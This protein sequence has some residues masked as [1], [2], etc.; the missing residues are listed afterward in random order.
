[1]LPQFLDRGPYT[2]THTHTYTGIYIYIYM[3]FLHWIRN[4]IHGALEG[5]ELH[6]SSSLFVHWVSVTHSTGR[7]INPHH[8]PNP[9]PPCHT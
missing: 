8:D 3:R 5:F 9:N 7:F 4:H 1:M 6:I 2:H